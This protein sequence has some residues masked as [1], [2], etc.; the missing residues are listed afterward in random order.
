MV[1]IDVK[2]RKYFII[3]ICF[4]CLV[5]LGC[6]SGDDEDTTDIGNPYKVSG[7]VQKGPFI[8]DTSITITE[9]FGPTMEPPCPRGRPKY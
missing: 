7:Y 6:G 9:L 3:I 1:W 4:L 2:I 8:K 5:T